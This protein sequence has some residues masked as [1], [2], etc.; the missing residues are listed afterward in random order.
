[1]LTIKVRVDEKRRVDEKMR[2]DEKNML[3]RKGLV[4]EIRRSLL[5]CLLF[6]ISHTKFTH[7]SWRLI[8][9]NA[10]VHLYLF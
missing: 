6:F 7:L 4:E 5:I 9:A 3:T 10:K 2:V 1:V 8:V